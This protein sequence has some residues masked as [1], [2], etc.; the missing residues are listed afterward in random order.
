M[1]AATASLI[2]VLVAVVPPATA[3]TGAQPPRGV[4]VVTSPLLMLGSTGLSD[5]FGPK[6]HTKRISATLFYACLECFLTPD[7]AGST[8]VLGATTLEAYLGAL[9]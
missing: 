7:R 8:R 2:T 3:V 4:L 6:G 5:I 1:I 9:K